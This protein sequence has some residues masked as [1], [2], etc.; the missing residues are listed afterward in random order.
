VRED[1]R[2]KRKHSKAFSRFS[3]VRGT[4]QIGLGNRSRVCAEVLYVEAYTLIDVRRRLV[5]TISQAEPGAG[6]GRSVVDVA[7]AGIRRLASP[8]NPHKNPT[9]Q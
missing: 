9:R 2:R 6:M 3:L 4:P 8:T 1:E 5:E 7:L